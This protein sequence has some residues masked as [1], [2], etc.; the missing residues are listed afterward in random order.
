MPPEFK[1]N[2]G[3]SKK[4]TEKSHEKSD[5]RESS[6]SLQEQGMFLTTESSSPARCAFLNENNLSV[7]M[8]IKSKKKR[9]GPLTCIA[10]YSEEPILIFMLLFLSSFTKILWTI[11]GGRAGWGEIHATVYNAKCWCSYLWVRDYWLLTWE[12]EILE[13]LERMFLNSDQLLPL[14]RARDP[15]SS[16]GFTAYTHTETHTET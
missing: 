12:L 15:I 4:K 11:W 16:S 8:Q 6:G 2:V 7:K 14:Q 9:H 5:P 3:A 1:R 13:G 10:S